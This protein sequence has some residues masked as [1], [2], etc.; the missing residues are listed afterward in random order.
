MNE[1]KGIL[2]LAQNS[3]YDYVK[4]ACLNAMS[5]C[6]TNPET[7]ISLVTN[8]IVPEKYKKY[9]DKIIEIPWNDAA[10]SAEW[11]IENRWKLYHAT[12][13]EK[14]IVLDTD[15]LVLQDLTSWWKF[16]ENYD[17]YFNTPP[18]SSRRGC[19]LL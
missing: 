1:G 9:F 19:F 7:K 16:L 11:K 13:Y 14:T 4:Q 8:D 2:M 18:G 3:E 5:I 12:P 6:L 17:L 15:M 10:S